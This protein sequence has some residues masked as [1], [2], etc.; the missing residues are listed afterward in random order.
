MKT[1]S[2]VKFGKGYYVS[3][4]LSGRMM[5]HEYFKTKKDAEEKIKKLKKDGYTILR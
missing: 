5:E 1:I 3:T 2:I 4:R